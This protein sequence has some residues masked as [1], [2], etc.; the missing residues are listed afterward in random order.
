MLNVMHLKACIFDLDGV[1]TE[2]SIVHAKAWKL[3]FDEFLSQESIHNG[4][5]YPLFSDKDYLLYLDGK[6]R[7]K[8]IE[9]FLKSRDIVLEFGL[10]TDSENQRTV[11]GLGNK[12]NKAFV[13]ILARDGVK[14]YK[15][16]VQLIDDVRASGIKVGLVTSSKN[17]GLI[18]KL[19]NI[20]HLF[21]VIIDGND[22]EQKNI[23]GK[24]QPDTFLTCARLLSVN[25]NACIVAEDAISGVQAAH[26]GQFGLVVG[27]DRAGIKND[28]L[29][30]GADVVFTD[31][32]ETSFEDLHALFSK[33]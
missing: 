31:F 1:V 15:S 10:P 6:P 5:V 11:C 30:N 18:L 24:P 29:E 26:S 16:T 20:T 33:N 22:A 7:Y 4:Q 23:P 28:L 32:A 3:L 14:I 21:D 19:A 12:K 9:A 2:T 27:L 8:G 17:C 13:D 25:P